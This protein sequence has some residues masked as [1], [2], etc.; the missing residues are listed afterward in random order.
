MKKNTKTKPNNVPKPEDVAWCRQLIRVT[1][2]GGVW[3]IPRSG[4][5][6]RIDKNNN[7]L[8]LVVPGNDDGEDFAATKTHFAVIGWDVVMDAKLKEQSNG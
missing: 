8:V 5:A 3:G 2:D 6:F 7:R 1:K 4:T